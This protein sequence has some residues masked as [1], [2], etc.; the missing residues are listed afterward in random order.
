MQLE[1]AGRESVTSMNF[2]SVL[3]L[4]F[5]SRDPSS[6]SCFLNFTQ[7]DDTGSSMAD[8]KK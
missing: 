2:L 8:R 3:A 4:Q 1:K 6:V 7:T 5:P